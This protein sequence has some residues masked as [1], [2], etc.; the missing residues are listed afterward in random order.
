MKKVYFILLYAL[1]SA[2]LFSG[3][4]L[5]GETVPSGEIPRSAESQFWTQD[6][7]KG[8]VYGKSLR[9][10]PVRIGS[11]TY[12]RGICGHAMMTLV[13]QLDG[14]ADEFSADFGVDP[15]IHPKDNLL[16]PTNTRFEILV[17]RVKIRDF[18]LNPGDDPFPVTINLKGKQQLEITGTYGLDGFHRQRPVLGNPVFKTER[19]DKLKQAAAQGAEKVRAARAFRPVYPTPPSWCRKISWMGYENVY[20]I[21]NGILSVTLIPEA[22]GR[23]AAFARSGRDNILYTALPDAKAP[24]AH[25]GIYSDRKMSGHFLR[26]VPNAGTPLDPVLNYGRYAV[27]FPRPHVL[28]MSSAPSGRH[29]LRIEYEIELPRNSDTLIVR[30]RLVN[31]APF[32][33]T[34]GIWSLTRV[35]TERIQTIRVPPSMNCYKTPEPLIKKQGFLVCEDVRNR[36]N[37]PA[38]HYHPHGKP[39]F[40]LTL[41]DGSRLKLRYEYGQYVPEVWPLHYFGSKLFSELE[42]HSVPQILKPNESAESVEHWTLTAPP[43][44]GNSPQRR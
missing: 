32:C 39:E 14:L 37:P 24:L 29:F 11:K 17:D 42:S 18:Y 1:L 5:A 26:L 34:L 43:G 35:R 28:K 40:D 6:G 16:E 9:G 8:P 20:V 13:W 41:T 31:T 25:E 12:R 30:N 33:Q 7:V 2:S 38:F 3:I 19:P 15:E 4:P 23:I 10:K 27:E 22:G 21:D 36:K 44:N